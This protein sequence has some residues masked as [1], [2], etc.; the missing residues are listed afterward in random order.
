MSANDKKVRKIISY[1]T[2][3]TQSK[4]SLLNKRVNRLIKAY[5]NDIEV[6][7]NLRQQIYLITDMWLDKPKFFVKSLN[8]EQRIQMEYIADTFYNSD[9]GTV[10]RYRYFTSKGFSTFANNKSLD[11]QGI[12]FF[13]AVFESS[14]WNELKGLKDFYHK[15]GDTYDVLENLYGKGV[16]ATDAKKLLQN[17]RNYYNKWLE[18]EEK[19]KQV[20][21]TTKGYRE[22][23]SFRE[24]VDTFLLQRGLTDEALQESRKN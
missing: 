5:G 13:G 12:D 16:S 9:T 20:H 23:K 21:G 11:K 17:Y 22:R 1:E 7:N 2:R 15:G 18:G 6:I 10:T 19:Y 14:V 24:T 3:N 4:F 8:D